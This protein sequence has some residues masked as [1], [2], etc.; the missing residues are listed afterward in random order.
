MRHKIS[1]EA[2]DVYRLL[3]PLPAQGVGCDIREPKVSEEGR[4]H[5]G[6]PVSQEQALASDRHPRGDRHRVQEGTEGRLGSVAQEGVRAGVY[7]LKDMEL[8]DYTEEQL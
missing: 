3:Q 6:V 2:A 4:L 8:K 1:E 5:G 7:V